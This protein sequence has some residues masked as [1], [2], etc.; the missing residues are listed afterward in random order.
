MNRSDLI[1]QARGH[2][3]ETQQETATAMGYDL[4]PWQR[5]ESG[6]AKV[7]DCELIAMAAR[8]N[9][10]RTAEDAKRVIEMATTPRG[11]K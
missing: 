11:S 6:R 4:S 1:R 7:R 5:K 10:I 2:I 9:G 8:V 3:N